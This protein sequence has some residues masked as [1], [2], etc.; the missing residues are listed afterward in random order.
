MVTQGHHLQL[1][2]GEVGTAILCGDPDRAAW[3]ADRLNARAL[4]RR[5]GFDLYMADP[6][7]AVVAT[8]IGG[9]ATAIAAEELILAGAYVLVRLGSCGRLDPN[10]RPGDLVISSGCVREDGTSAAYLPPSVP[11]V[12]SAELTAMLTEAA[13]SGPVRAHLGLTHCKDDYYGEKVGFLPDTEAARRRWRAVRDSGAL[14]TEMEAAALFAVA[15]LRGVAA[16]A[17]FLVVGAGP[18]SDEADAL[19]AALDA[20]MASIKQFNETGGCARLS[21]R[22][23]DAAV[24][25]LR[26]G[27]LDVSD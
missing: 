9:P 7:L 2:E 19:P 13:M 25:F 6:S 18:D 11:A 4:G 10:V 27:G 22:S 15:R 1:R 5:R 23:P 3:V 24:S 14:A 20:V 17:L 16:A 8:G 12:P 21:P 26:A